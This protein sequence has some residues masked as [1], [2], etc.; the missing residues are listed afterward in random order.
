M[1]FGETGFLGSIAIIKK[2]KIVKEVENT[3]C[4]IHVFILF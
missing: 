4:D 1:D 2:R 3:D